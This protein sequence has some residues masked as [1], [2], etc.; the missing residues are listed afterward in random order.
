VSSALA[1]VGCGSAL[2]NVATA[3]VDNEPLKVTL[4]GASA[5]GFHSVLG[6]TIAEMVRR[7]Y[8]GSSIGYEPG[9]Q[10]GQLVRCARDDIKLTLQTTIEL[11]LALEGH[12]VFPRRFEVEELPI[13]AKIIDHQDIL[14]FVSQDAAK[15]YGIRSLNDIRNKKTP[16]NMSFYP[17]GNLFA[18]ALVFDGLFKAYGITEEQIKK[19]G[20]QAY[21]IGS[22]DAKRLYEDRKIDLWLGAGWHPD[23]KTLEVN[24]AVPLVPISPDPAIVDKIAKRF[25]LKTRFLKGGTYRFVPDDY[26][27]PMVP[28]YLVSSPKLSEAD[29]YKL[30]KSLYNNFD[31]LRAAHPTFNALQRHMIAEHDQFQLHPGARTFYREVGLLPSPKP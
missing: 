20:G 1:L 31:Y 16:L 21:Y 25:G 15:K 8:P 19:W 7:E 30:A 17:R 24:R 22:A 29:A 27:T 3:Q 11:Q 14:L 2:F 10:A 28:T 23:S 26:Y 12:E 4:G 5:G 6:E 9:T 13:I 18:R